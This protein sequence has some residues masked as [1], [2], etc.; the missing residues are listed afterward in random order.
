[1]KLTLNSQPSSN[2]ATLG[3]LLVN[4]RFECFTLEDVMREIPGKP[5]SQWKVPGKTAIPAGK[6]TIEI[7]FSQRFQTRLPILV[8]VPGF[9]G[10]R[11]HNGNSA[12]DTEGCILVGQSR[13]GNTIG[14][15]RAALAALFSQIDKALS[16]NEPVFIEIVRAT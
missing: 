14:R 2:G 7:T 16:Q 4:V 15:S 6:Y 13:N 1:M 9:E 8:D 12:E 11:I 5:V 10:I 3:E